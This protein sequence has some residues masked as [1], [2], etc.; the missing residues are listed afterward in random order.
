MTLTPDGGRVEIEIFG[1]GVMSAH[2]G[3]SVWNNGDAIREED[4]ERV[5]DKFEQVQAST[6]RRVGGTGLG[7]S[8]SRAIVEGHGGKIWVEHQRVGTKFVF[9]LPAA[10]AGSASP[11]PETTLEVVP[12]VDAKTVE[13]G[14]QVL[15]VDAG[16][17]RNAPAR[18]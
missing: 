14:R 12:G 16:Q 9:T 6:T 17:P 1:P 3:V 11:R 13:S 4:R 18:S 5:F 8:I 7:L 15:V 10:P 2:V